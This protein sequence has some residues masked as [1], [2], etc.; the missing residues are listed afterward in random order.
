M[1]YT[2]LADL[3]LFVHFGYVAFVALGLLATWIGYF[4][5]RGWAR[6]FYFRAAH[7]ASM[8]IV[9]AESVFGI[10]CPLTIWE[11]DLRA[12]AGGGGAYQ[13]SFME[14]WI[15]RLMFFDLSAGTFTIIYV[16]FLA[17]LV[18]SLIVIPPERPSWLRRGSPLQKFK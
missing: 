6:N 1:L 15:H 14:H 11:N 3:I 2:F 13:E 7:L 12:A 5:R 16:T 10:E 18:L 9:V 8:A 4:L 17:L